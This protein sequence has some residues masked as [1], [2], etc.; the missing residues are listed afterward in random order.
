L[1]KILLVNTLPSFLERNASLLSKIGFKLYTATSAI[2]AMAIHRAERVDLIIAM[3]DMPEVGGDMLCSLIRKDQ[4]LRKVS[5]LLICYPAPEQIEKASRCGANAWICKPVQPGLLLQEVGKLIAIPTRLDHRARIH[6]IVRSKWFS[7]ISRNISVSGIL[8][9][10]D[11]VLDPEAIITS[12]SFFIR[13]R[14][15]ISDGKVVRSMSIPGGLYDYGVQ[16]IGLAP[17]Y[18]K[19]IETF[20]DQSLK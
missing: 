18:R 1:K 11:K 8:F 2:E 10:T 15:I 17:E 19:E 3:L 6:G 4:E 9:Q 20:V 16:F 13:S 5:I 7:G 14:E 12:M